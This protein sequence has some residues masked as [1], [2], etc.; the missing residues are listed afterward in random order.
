MP[1]LGAYDE[2]EEGC[3][4]SYELYET[5][6]GTW[7]AKLVIDTDGEDAIEVANNIAKAMRVI[8]KTSPDHAKQCECL[9]CTEWKLHNAK[10]RLGK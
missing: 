3:N 10:D 4:V 9:L 5:K 7:R 6:G 2:L 1:K 8:S